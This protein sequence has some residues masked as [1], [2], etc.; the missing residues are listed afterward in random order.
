MDIKVD[1]AL[2]TSLQPRNKERKPNNTRRENKGGGEARCRMKV[3]I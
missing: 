2:G 3:N 1:I